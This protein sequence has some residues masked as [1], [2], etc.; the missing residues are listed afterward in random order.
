MNMTDKI[1]WD[2][3]TTQK[4]LEDNNRTLG[5]MESQGVSIC[6]PSAG[7]YVRIKPGTKYTD[8]IWVN[9]A[10]HTVAKTQK[11]TQYIIKGE[12]KEVDNKLQ[13]ILSL[14]DDYITEKHSQKTWEAGKDWVQYSGPYFTSDEYIRSIKS[15]LNEWLVLGEDAIK[16]ENR[17]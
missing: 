14:V 6:K 3:K 2:S 10:F 15:L 4:T 11:E 1:T 7:T 9:V 16:F 17:F 5:E 13:N 12:S 8:L